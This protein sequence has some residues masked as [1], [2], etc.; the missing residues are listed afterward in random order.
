MHSQV[1]GFTL[2]YPQWAIRPDAMQKRSNGFVPR[3]SQEEG[4]LIDI[5]DNWPLE[6]GET[7]SVCTWVYLGAPASRCTGCTCQAPPSAP[8]M[9]SMA[10][11][12]TCLAVTPICQ[13]NH[14]TPGNPRFQRYHL[15]PSAN[16]TTTRCM[17]VW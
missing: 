12:H 9:A 11:R 4:F 13:L 16:Q 10:C 17:F 7:T 2:L 15:L 8:P 6:R 5:R 1:P 14:P 3:D